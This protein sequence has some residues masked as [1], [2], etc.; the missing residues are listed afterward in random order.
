MRS[1][2]CIQKFEKGHFTITKR[3]VYTFQA[4]AKNFIGP[5]MVGST[6]ITTVQVGDVENISLL[7]FRVCYKGIHVFFIIGN[8]KYGLV[9]GRIRTCAKPNG[10]HRLKLGTTD[11]L[12]SIASYILNDSIP[13]FDSKNYL[14][15]ISYVQNIMHSGL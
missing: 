5:A 12:R 11:K 8:K 14:M 4:V 6:I 2:C 10:I 3:L 15:K 1:T 13:L 7:V 9:V